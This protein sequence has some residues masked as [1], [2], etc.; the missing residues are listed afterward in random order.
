MNEK[1]SFNRGR[2]K[3]VYYACQRSTASWQRI[4]LYE[5]QNG[6]KDIWGFTFLDC[7]NDQ[8]VFFFLS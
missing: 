4:F 5:L 6:H 2:K 8:K 7:S 1:K 3:F